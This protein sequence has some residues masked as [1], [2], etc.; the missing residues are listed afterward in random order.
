MHHDQV[1]H[2]GD[3]ADRREVACRVEGQA[4][5]RARGSPA[6][7]RWSPGS[8]VWPS[9]VAR[10]A[11][12]A[13]MLPPA[14]G[15]FSTTTGWPSRSPAPGR[16]ARAVTSVLP[17]AAKPTIRRIGRSGAHVPVRGQGGR[18]RRR[19]FPAAGGDASDGSLD[20]SGGSDPRSRV[21]SRLGEPIHVSGRSRP[22][23]IGSRQATAGAPPGPAPPRGSGPAGWRPRAAA[24]PAS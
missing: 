19:R 3:R 5:G 11:A 1:R 6:A 9:G 15:R 20:R 21:V 8:S 16:P 24:A 4:C 18:A 23:T 2:E 22:P 17:P 14:P 7:C 12:S 13:A 10:A